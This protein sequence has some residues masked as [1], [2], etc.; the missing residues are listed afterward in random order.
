MLSGT[1][2]A[3]RNGRNPV[4]AGSVARAPGIGGAL[5]GG[6]QFAEGSLPAGAQGGD[7]QGAAQRAR[8][9]AGQVEQRVGV[10]HAQRAGTGPGLDDLVAGLD[11]PLAD[12]AHVEA[13]PVVADQQRGQVGL[14]EA[15]PDPV[16]GD[17][18]LGDL[19]LRLA[20]PVPVPDA[21]LVVG[22]AVD[23]EVLPELAVHEVV[24][25]EVLLPVLVGLDL[26]DQ[27]GPLLAA[28]SVQVALAVPVD[29]EPADH[30]GPDTE[31]FH[32]PV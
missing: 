19:E 28:V 22:Q 21:H 26:V 16:A 6:E 14:A 17:P 27:Y 11:V 10:G 9:V 25:P 32:T 15:Q 20:D 3:T 13:G 29:V 24:A 1:T 8:V 23:G 30:C 31:C 2:W 18:G 12:H 4:Q 7:L 5:G